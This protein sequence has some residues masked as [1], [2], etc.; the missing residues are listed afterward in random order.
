MKLAIWDTAGQERF[1]TL[2]PSYYRGGNLLIL[3]VGV[4]SPRRQINIFPLISGQGII[5]VYDVSCRSTFESLEHWLLEVDT[6][7]TRSDAIKMLVGNKIDAVIY[8]LNKNKKNC[9][10]YYVH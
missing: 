4:S 5:L 8:T 7:C 10:L 6:Y 9:L 3:S 2:T 1:R